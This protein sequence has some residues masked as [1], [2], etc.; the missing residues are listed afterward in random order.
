MFKP[1]SLHVSFNR[2]W[3][4]PRLIY[5][6]S[7]YYE[8]KDG[9]I[10]ET[11]DV[12]Q[13]RQEIVNRAAT[14]GENLD[15]V[16]NRAKEK[17][18]ASEPMSIEDAEAFI[19]AVEGYINQEANSILDD[20]TINRTDQGTSWYRDLGHPDLQPIK[21]VKNT[22]VTALHE[23]AEQHKQVMAD[24]A[25]AVNQSEKVNKIYDLHVPKLRSAGPVIYKM[26]NEKNPTAITI[27]ERRAMEQTLATIESNVLPQSAAGLQAIAEI[28]TNVASLPSAPLTTTI[29]K[30]LGT[31]NDRFEEFTLAHTIVSH[32]SIEAGNYLKAL[33]DLGDANYRNDDKAYKKAKLAVEAARKGYNAINLPKSTIGKPMDPTVVG[34]K[35][36]TKKATPS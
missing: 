19:K 34:A 20:K 27:E 16:V 24:I 25:E 28:R 17:L 9:A 10:V 18:S 1:K 23:A 7:P 33:R 6:E 5:I 36:D 21:N 2:E 14:L 30:L 3:H 15:G 22:A 31:I 12:K 35:P 4:T 8:K 26:V 32:S 13:V 29:Q 11:T